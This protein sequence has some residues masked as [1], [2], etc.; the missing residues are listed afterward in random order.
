MRK[1]GVF[2]EFD[3]N[4]PLPADTAPPAPDMVN[5]PP[6]YG[7]GDIECVDAIRA[8]LTAEE[9]RGWCKGNVVKYIWRER[10]KGGDESLNKGGWYL[11]EAVK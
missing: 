3:M 8:M 5:H 2:P 1:F 10:H 7:Q 11:T 6:H 4:R 9:F